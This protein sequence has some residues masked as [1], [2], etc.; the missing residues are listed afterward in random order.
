MSGFTN[1]CGPAGGPPLHMNYPAGDVIAGVFGAFSIAAAVARRRGFPDEPP[2]EIDLSATEALLRILDALP[3]EHERTGAVR[4]P[5]GNRATYTAPSN[6]Y[7]TLDG[8]WV[9]LVASSDP[10]VRWLIAVYST[11]PSL[12]T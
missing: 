2:A 12:R 7:R 1:L 5:A 9:T 10:K 8:V 4:G 3:V 11:L 6:M